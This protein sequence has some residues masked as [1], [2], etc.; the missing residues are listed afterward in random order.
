MHA[1]ACVSWGEAERGEE[2]LKQ[3]PHRAQ[4]P[5]QGSISQPG[6]H[7]LSHKQDNQ[8]HHAGPLLCLMFLMC[9]PPTTRT[10]WVKQRRKKN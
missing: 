9:L 8:L 5:M 6:D 1:Q 3:T 7:N 4:S 2:H 10:E